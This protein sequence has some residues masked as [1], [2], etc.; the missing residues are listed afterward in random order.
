MQSLEIL[1]EVVYTVTT[2]S[3]K[4]KH[5]DSYLSLSLCVLNSVDARIITNDDL[6]STWK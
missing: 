3:W 4:V 5:I 2:R 6:T 1:E